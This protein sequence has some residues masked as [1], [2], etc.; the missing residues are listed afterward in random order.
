MLIKKA[1][2]VLMVIAITMIFCV[3]AWSEP[4]P[5]QTISQSKSG[6]LAQQKSA[7]QET[8]SEKFV[9]TQQ[10]IDAISHV[11]EATADKTKPKQN[12]PSPDNSS[13][14]FSFFL[15]IFTGLL[16][17]VGAGQCY[18]IFKTLKETQVVAK[19][20]TDSAQVAETALHVAERAYLKIEKFE[21]V[22]F[23]TGD[24]LNVRYEIHNV[25][26]TP[27]QIM[28][29]LTIV[30]IVEKDSFKTPVY[31]IERGLI[32]PKQAFIQPD[33]KASMIGI[34]KEPVTPEQFNSVQND[35]KL[36]FTWGKITFRD[37]F[38]KTWVNGFGAVFSQVYG[39]T[40]M[41]GY[42]YTKE[43]E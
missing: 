6:K 3:V 30:D 24:H 17:L 33:E 10:L 36:I 15:T 19:A 13:Y 28:E 25:G 4:N 18:I 11:I 16:V 5:K 40:M 21:V 39:L 2:I 9:T 41:D 43:Y 7:K 26:H 37:V 38:G 29:S 23:S 20:A 14:W 32:G 22:N 12:P 42:I 31:D 34:S 8:P 27:A 1:F 35:S